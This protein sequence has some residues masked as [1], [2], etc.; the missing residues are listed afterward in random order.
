V[1]VVCETGVLRVNTSGGV[2][3]RLHTDLLTE[4][5][6]HEQFMRLTFLDDPLININLI[7]GTKTK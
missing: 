5:K 7:T 4:F 1:I 6:V 3:W 2:M